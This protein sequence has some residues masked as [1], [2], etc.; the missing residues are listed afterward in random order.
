M[1]IAPAGLDAR[2]TDTIA[3]HGWWL[4]SRAAGLL[5]LILVTISTALALMVA[6]RMVH[7]PALGAIHQQLALTAIV[8]IAV[9]GITLVGDPWLRP[10]I[11]GIA[12]PF[13]M[14]Y[15]PLWT[16]FG[17]VAGYVA[18]ILGLSFYVRT[19][20]GPRLWRSAHRLIIAVYVLGVVH[21]LGAGTDAS[22]VWLRWW[23]AL[24][25]PVI[26]VLFV[27]RVRSALRRSSSFSRPPGSRGIDLSRPPTG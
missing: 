13:T 21:V 23:F 10:G 24:T 1:V 22:T 9:H 11:G 3:T 4:A 14:A 20:I 27:A 15:R 6:G 2:L 18:A 16:G 12:I 26:M 5:A 19:R 8:A 7:W 25:A 17:I